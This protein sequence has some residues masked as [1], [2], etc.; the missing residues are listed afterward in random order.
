M[1]VSRASTS[2]LENLKE[3]SEQKI[4]SEYIIRN[5]NNR[6]IERQNKLTR[7]I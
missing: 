3:G 1:L 6:L 7:R 5:L 2:S 4:V